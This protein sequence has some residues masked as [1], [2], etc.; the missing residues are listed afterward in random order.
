MEK[1]GEGDLVLYK[2]SREACG[3]QMFYLVMSGNRLAHGAE[4]VQVR[5]A[6]KSRKF[7]KRFSNYSQTGLAKNYALVKRAEEITA[8]S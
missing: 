6:T 2:W 7:D 5:R 3:R 1:F 4:F 8:L